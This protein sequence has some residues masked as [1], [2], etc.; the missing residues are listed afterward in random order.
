M[1]EYLKLLVDG[2]GETCPWRNKGCDGM[3]GWILWKVQD[4]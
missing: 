3:L 1:E 2:H 4:C